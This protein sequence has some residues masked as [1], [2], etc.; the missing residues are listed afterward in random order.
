M[1]NLLEATNRDGTQHWGSPGPDPLPALGLGSSWVI[2]GS[3]LRVTVV[4][5]DDSGATLRF[6]PRKKAS[7]TSPPAVT[8]PVDV[9]SEEER[10]LRWT[11]VP[12]A[13]AYIVRADDKIIARF[14]GDSAE[15]NIT[16]IAWWSDEQIT[17]T[18]IGSDGAQSDAV[19]V[20]VDHRGP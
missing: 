13:I 18:T 3:G 6:T 2:P 9:Q 8:D 20:P 14:A 1:L 17:I 11:P 15:A 19:V 5:T 16:S 7:K 4:A 10:I 12:G